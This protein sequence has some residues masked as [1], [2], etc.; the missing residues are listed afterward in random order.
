M[1]SVYDRLELILF[2]YIREEIMSVTHPIH[3]LNLKSQLIPLR[4]EINS[5]LTKAIDN[6]AFIGGEGLKSFEANYAKFCESQYCIGV[7]NGT[8]ALYS[9]FWALDLKPGD[10]VIVPAMSFIATLEPLTQLGLQPV[11][12]DIDPTTYTLDSVSVAK[13]ITSKTKAILPVH[14]YGQPA[15]MASLQNLA[16][17]HELFIVEDAA[18]AH[19]AKYNGQRVGSLGTAAGF[20]FYPG[21]NLG[22]FGDGG[23]VITADEQLADRIRRFSDHG[24]LTKYEH[25]FPGVNSRLDAIQALVLDI[26]LKHLDPWN[27]SRAQWA[28]LYNELLADIPQLTLPVLGDNRTHVYHQ[29]VVCTPKRDDLMAYLKERNIFTG[30]HYPI[31]LHLQPAYQNLGYSKGDFPHAE[32]LGETCLSLPMFAELTAEEIQTVAEAIRTYFK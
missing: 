30:L 14:L 26:K 23:A 29:Y 1:K 11:L 2:E 20:S 13:V 5:V 27:Q 12:A 32:R 3:Q 7:G 25:E 28:N 21:K 19:G 9:I 16:Q 4:D 17:A 22:A 15:D 24:R 10:E 6:T 18:Q 8:D 31:P